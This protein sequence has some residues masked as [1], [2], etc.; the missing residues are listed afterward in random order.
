MDLIEE[1]GIELHI[2]NIV[3]CELFHQS[4]VHVDILPIIKL[5]DVF[6]V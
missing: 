2:V 3:V 5:P 6:V 1:S 4:T